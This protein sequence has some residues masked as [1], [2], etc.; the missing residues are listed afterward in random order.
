MSDQ[1]FHRNNFHKNTFCIFHEVNPGEITSLPLGYKSKSGSS[2]YFTE[3]G[4]YRLSN[5]WGRAANCKWRL[6]S[7]GNTM[8]RMKLGFAAWVAFHRDNDIEKLYYIEA[9]PENNTVLFQHK[10]SGN[11]KNEVLRTASETAKRIKQ[12]RHLLENDAWTKYYPGTKPETLKEKII[13][14]MIQTD[15]TL[16]QIKATL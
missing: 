8:G 6:Q 15:L 4:V 1:G 12:I 5:H 13:A 11:Y 7:A 3:T 9:D 10:D 2:Y 16:Q 14:Q